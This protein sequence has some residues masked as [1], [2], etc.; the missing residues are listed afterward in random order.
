MLQASYNLITYRFIENLS[1]YWRAKA[2]KS[3]SF[4]SQRLMSLRLKEEIRVSL[5]YFG[6]TQHRQLRFLITRFF[7]FSN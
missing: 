3:L 5:V 2:D 1:R 7:V 4:F 6:Q